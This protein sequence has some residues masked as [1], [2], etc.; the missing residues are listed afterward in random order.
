MTAY[1]VT[2][3]SSVYTNAPGGHAF[4]GDSPGA[5]SLTVDADAFLVAAGGFNAYGALLANTGAWTVNVN[6]SIVSPYDAGLALS[7]GNPGVSTITVG[8]EG[9]IGGEY[10]MFVNSAASVQN[11]GA[12]SGTS[13]I[14]MYMTGAVAHAV[15]NTGTVE[16]GIYSASD[17]AGA[18]TVTNSG[19][20][21]GQ[22]S[23]GGGSD[24]FTNVATVGGALVSG[25]V[26]GS[27]DLGDGND[28]FRG[29]ANAET[30]Q[31]NNGS[32][33]VR[34]GGGNDTYIGGGATPGPSGGDG[35]DVIDGGTGIDT[36]DATGSSSAVEI[37]LDTVAH[38]LS[39]FAPG[40]FRV[41]ARTVD[42][43]DVAGAGSDTLTSIENVKGG[44]GAD[45]IYGSA[46][47]NVIEGNGGSD[48][49]FGYGG[50]DVVKGGASSDNI[51]G[52]G[53]RDQLSGGTEADAFIFTSTSHS[54]TTAATRDVILD[55]EDAGDVIA[56]DRI[57]AKAG[58]AANDAF[59][60][61][62]TDVAF[63]GQAG[64]LR[65]V[66]TATGQRVQ[67]DLNGDGRADF[68]IDLRDA[69]YA[70]TLTE[71]DFA[72]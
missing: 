39:P 21:S 56:L 3:A 23:L 70:I 18:D 4:G 52:G 49:L 68:S 2:P 31:D 41:A 43:D 15:T 27:I 44:S 72:L 11:A 66:H 36:Y 38:D 51:V 7:P 50:N 45:I 40:A 12:I 20:I 9:S 13:G 55:F 6:G 5:D 37:N 30:V 8:A 63:R 29:G 19:T 33:T 60:F 59:T 65:S 34:L 1:R 22:V 58:T 48:F 28:R 17:Q 46:G 69:T 61:I 62:G 53:A 54:G 16:G 24:A 35:L 42:G 32:D 14:A 47:A 26:A 67:A 25:T 71:A 57:D 10:G 64:E